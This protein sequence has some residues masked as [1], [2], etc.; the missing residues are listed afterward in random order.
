[1]FDYTWEQLEKYNFSTFTQIGLFGNTIKEMK[2]ND[3]NRKFSSWYDLD[4]LE[5]DTVE[6]SNA[7]KQK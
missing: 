6:F 3:P 4:N 1:M 5:E 2:K 7:L